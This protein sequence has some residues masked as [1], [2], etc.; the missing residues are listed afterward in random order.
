MQP[1]K[2][3]TRGE[4]WLTII[5]ALFLSAALGVGGLYGG[6]YLFLLLSKVDTSILTYDTLIQ[7]W[8]LWQYKKLHT[9]IRL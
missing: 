7:S 4:V 8:K 1:R 2:N 9:P 6:G 5:F 3:I